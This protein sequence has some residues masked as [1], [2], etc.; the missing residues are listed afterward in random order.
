M[1]AARSLAQELHRHGMRLI[2]GGGTLGMMGEVAKTL[3]S[4]SGPDSVHGIIPTPLLSYE[5]APASEETASVSSKAADRERDD[6]GPDT[7][8]FGRTTVVKNMHERKQLMAK[9]VG[10]GGPGSGFIALSGGYGTMEEV[11]EMTTWNQLGIHDKP[12]VLLNVEGYWDALLRW[13]R[14]ASSAGFIS[15][16]NVNILQSANGAEDAIKALQTYTP[17]EGRLKLSWDS[18]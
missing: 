2:Y 12:V 5:A 8:V 9:E 15:D 10:A 17:S 16:V 1:A 4:L 6:S 13:V 3:V 11:M 14:D 7:S 18:T